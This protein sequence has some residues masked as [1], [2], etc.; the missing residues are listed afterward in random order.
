MAVEVA[1]QGSLQMPPEDQ[2]FIVYLAESIQTVK[3]W[4]REYLG[5]SNLV[6]ICSN[7]SW[8]DTTE[9]PGKK[10]W[11]MGDKVNHNIEEYIKERK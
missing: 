7:T 10:K 3:T 4:K 8:E 2:D 9:Y 6:V 1:S 11:G 5:K